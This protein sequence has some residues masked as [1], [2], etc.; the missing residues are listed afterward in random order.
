MTHFDYYITNNS[1]N[2]GFEF[3]PT[4]PFAFA[5][6]TNTLP[7]INFVTN[8]FN[9]F[10]LTNL[11]NLAGL[12]FNKLEDLEERVGSL[13]RFVQSQSDTMS[14][15]LFD[16]AL[17]IV[18]I[19]VSIADLTRGIKTLN[20]L[21]ELSAGRRS[22]TVK[23]SIADDW[24]ESLIAAKQTTTTYDPTKALYSSSVYNY[25][26]TYSKVD[27]RTD[28]MKDLKTVQDLDW[29]TFK[30]SRDARL[31]LREIMQ[32]SSTNFIESQ[33]FFTKYV[34][35]LANNKLPFGYVNAHKSPIAELGPVGKILADQKIL[36][37][38][39]KSFLTN[40]YQKYPYHTSASSHLIDINEEGD[41]IA[42]TRF[43][44]VGEPSII[45]PTNAKNP[46]IKLGYLKIEHKYNLDSDSWDLVPW[47]QI[48][49]NNK[50]AYTPEDISML[51]YSFG[52]KL[53]G[54]TTDQMWLHV[55]LAT[56]SRIN[57][58][59]VLQSIP[60]ANSIFHNVMDDL[61]FFSKRGSGFGYN[62]LNN[63]CQSF[64]KSF[65]SIVSGDSIKIN[66]KATD[67]TRF[68]QDFINSADEYF[69]NSIY[70][71]SHSFARQKVF[72]DYNNYIRESLL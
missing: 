64:V 16:I 9:S 52:G 65:A 63:N 26:H 34:K 12:T 8:D 14:L 66:L 60:V 4:D 51:Y 58:R 47:N 62:L 48:K 49:A 70:M 53:E 35:Q 41:L 5:Y 32:L 38:Q 56:S 23:N 19:G 39:E 29:N 17:N 71:I 59:D 13:E 45:G 42:V 2:W 50:D 6:A 15:F 18:G 27:F 22:A 24:S 37:K 55:V 28:Y 54:Y 69:K 36:T 67:F 10:V 20:A 44:G 3:F 61:L 33:N 1:L 46:A 43:A 68:A 7:G 21:N 40:N 57:S 31:D 11:D 72:K 25:A 30:N